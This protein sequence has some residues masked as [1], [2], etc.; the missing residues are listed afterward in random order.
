MEFT[1]SYEFA[2]AALV[3]VQVSSFL[4]HRLYGDSLFD[5]A[6]N[7]RGIKISLGRQHIQMSDLI[8]SDIV[9]QEAI[10]FNSDT[11]RLKMEK[12]MKEKKVTEAVVIEKNGN[13]LGKILFHNLI[14]N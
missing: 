13:Y 4:T 11:S 2:V 10:V 1:G 5:M 7:D 14:S 12:I 9:T 8:L 6:L 3:A